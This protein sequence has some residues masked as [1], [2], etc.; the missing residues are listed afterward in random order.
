MSKYRIQT[1]SQI[2]GLAPALIRAWEA[3]YSLVSPVRTA[4]GYRLYSEDDVAVL[5][6]A[7]RLVKG[8]MAPMEVAR[9]PRRE[10]LG[11]GDS[12]RSATPREQARPRDGERSRDLDQRGP[13]AEHGR[14]PPQ[15]FS[16]R[17]D[18][19]IDAFK[20][21]DNQRVEQLLGQ[22]LAMLPPVGVCR[23][24]LLPLLREVGDRWHRGEMSVAAEHFGSR[25]IKGKLKALLETMR[26]PYSERRVLCACPPGEQHDLGLLMFALMAAEQRWDTIYLG[27][28]LPV[29]DLA[30]AVERARPDLVALSV[31]QRWDA[32]ELSRFLH[33]VRA[34]VGTKQ[35][36]LVGGGGIGGHSD[37]VRAAGC[38][39]LPESGRL[40]DLLD[41]QDRG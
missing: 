7:Q 38:L 12:D 37:V 5:Q 3:R 1:V 24:L 17:I 31:V 41:E 19:L 40:A 2:T 14:P 11:L 21:F 36:I 4:S 29:G 27:A 39:L 16:E 9:L 18:Q 34:A 33:Q 22:P 8:G 23:D 32:G 28:D 25:L 35:K 10:L 13:I 6:G 30:E 15:N 26:S 20:N